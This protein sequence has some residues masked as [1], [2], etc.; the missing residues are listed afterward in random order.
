VN[1]LAAIKNTLKSRRFWLWEICGALIY[2]IP[3]AIRY[4]TEVAIS[5]LNFPGYWIGHL[6]PGNLLEKVLVN[7]F[8]TEAQAGS[9]GRF[10]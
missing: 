7:A 8:F 3:V 2:A 10:L 1:S 9:L 4:A 5:I 6:I